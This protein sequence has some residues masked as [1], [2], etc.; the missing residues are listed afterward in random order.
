MLCGLIIA[1]QMSGVRNGREMMPL[2]L[3]ARRFGTSQTL[4]GAMS[5][6]GSPSA[7]V[8]CVMTVMWNVWASSLRSV[9][10]SLTLVVAVVDDGRVVL[11]ACS[12]VWCPFVPLAATVTLDG[13]RP[14]LRDARP[15]YRGHDGQW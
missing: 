6:T 14:T 13:A 1:C 10:E 3:M 4:S 11:V 8:Y 12:C 15:P 5:R 2:D 9:S 7:T